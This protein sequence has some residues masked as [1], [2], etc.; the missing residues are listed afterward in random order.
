MHTHLG[1]ELESN[2]PD[3]SFQ[4]HLLSGTLGWSTIHLI[5]LAD[6]AEISFAIHAKKSQLEMMCT[7]W[8]AN[9]LESGV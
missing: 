6:P 2:M 4:Q 7:L 9:E 8:F 5:S 1:K 3:P